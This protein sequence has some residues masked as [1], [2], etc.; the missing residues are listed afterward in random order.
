M[1]VAKLAGAELG[2]T[3]RLH[4]AVGQKFVPQMEPW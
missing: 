2:R 4:M 3:V 1:T